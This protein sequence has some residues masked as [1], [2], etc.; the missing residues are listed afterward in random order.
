M[1]DALAPVRDHLIKQALCYSPRLREIDF[2]ARRIC[3]R[4][5]DRLPLRRLFPRSRWLLPGDHVDQFPP[6]LA[7]SR[8]APRNA[9]TVYTAI[10]P[11]D[12]AAIPAA[13][14]IPQM[15]W[16]ATAPLCDVSPYRNSASACVRGST[17][18]TASS[19]PGSA[20]MGNND[21]AKK[22]GTIA[23]TGSAPV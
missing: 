16:S 17:L 19:H 4:R 21:P 5:G 14:L 22:N 11:I 12:S 13:L 8:T 9:T 2:T 10:T 18:A 3:E 20:V 6:D 15:L 7:N 1:R 23:T